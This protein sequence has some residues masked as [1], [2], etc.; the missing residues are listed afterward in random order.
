MIFCG[1]F[2]YPFENKMDISG[3]DNEFISRPKIVNLE[4]LI[5]MARL[6]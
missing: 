2:V 3:L 5:F 6:Q 1:D 4:S